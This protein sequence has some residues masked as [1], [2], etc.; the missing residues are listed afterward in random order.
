VGE[1][2]HSSEKRASLLYERIEVFI[3]DASRDFFGSSFGFFANADEVYG[4]VKFSSEDF[5]RDLAELDAV[6]HRTVT[7]KR[8]SEDSFQMFRCDKYRTS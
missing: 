5:L 2:L 1:F 8:V 7:I 3:L 6:L 4:L